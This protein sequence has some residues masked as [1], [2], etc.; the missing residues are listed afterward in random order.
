ML[1]TLAREFYPGACLFPMPLLLFN[2]IL[3][4]SPHTDPPLPVHMWEVMV[5]EGKIR[6]INVDTSPC[7]FQKYQVN[8]SKGCL[9]P[10]VEGG[11]GQ[12]RKTGTSLALV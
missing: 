9:R 4:L 11:S 12:S 10:V 6:L 3:V 1:R 7:H 8:R 5:L 2:F